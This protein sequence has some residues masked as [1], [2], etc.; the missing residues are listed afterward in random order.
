MNQTNVVAPPQPQTMS[1]PCKVPALSTYIVG[2]EYSKAHSPHLRFSCSNAISGPSSRVSTS[3]GRTVLRLG[4][5]LTAARAETLILLRRSQLET[6]PVRR[7]RT[8]RSLASCWEISVRHAGFTGSS[9]CLPRKSKTSP[10]SSTSPG[11]APS[12]PSCSRRGP[13]ATGQ[14]SAPEKPATPY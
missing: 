4:S 7:R 5:S 9:E 10:S 8:C 3:A 11:A 1:T 14:Q 13:P 6:F 12:R 2:H